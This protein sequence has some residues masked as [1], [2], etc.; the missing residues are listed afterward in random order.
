MAPFLTPPE[1]FSVSVCNTGQHRELIAPML[2]FFG[3]ANVHTL[4]S[5]VAGQSLAELSARMLP[6]I[7]HWLENTKPD[8]V[9][10]QGDTQ[11]SFI[12]ALAAY[13]QKIPVAHI[14]AG[15]RTEDPYN[16]FPEEMNRRLI[17]QIAHY[18]FAPT[19]KAAQ[20][21]ASEGFNERVWNVGNTGIDAL[22]ATLKK[23]QKPEGLD[24]DETKKIIFVTAHRR[25]NH[26]RPLENICQA[27][28][29]IVSRYPDCQI[30]F[31]VHKNP[32]VLEIV[33]ERLGNIPNILLTEPM[34]YPETV[35]LL[36]ACYLVLT[37]SGGL[38]EEAPS[39]NKPVLVMRDETERTEGVIS[40][41]A[42]LVGTDPAAIIR[43]VAHLLEDK[44][45]YT[46][47]ATANS[48][49][50]NGDA[51]MQIWRILQNTTMESKAQ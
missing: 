24:L 32:K 47:M 18:H 23:V 5:C 48:P 40:G 37:D 7:S 16:P 2:A 6:E 34:D 39:L 10:V 38:Q 17:S 33:H 36:S 46:T 22:Y 30:V 28:S 21:L 11:S 44:P 20:K 9:F 12:G 51:A 35:W 45:A 42:Q 50:G 3:Y 43:A 1:G 29:E 19:E 27:L 41:A 26:G 13:Y 4:T 14:E 8:I 31:P 15:L 25:E 49:Y